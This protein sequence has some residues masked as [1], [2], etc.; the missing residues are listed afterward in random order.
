MKKI[1]K[2]IFTQAIMS[3]LYFIVILLIGRVAKL[4]TAETALAMACVAITSKR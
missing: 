2:D 3:M 1:L 4:S